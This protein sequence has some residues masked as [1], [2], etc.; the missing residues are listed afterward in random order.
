MHDSTAIILGTLPGQCRAGGLPLGI[1][2]FPR[3]ERGAGRNGHKVSLRFPLTF[4]TK[5][6]Q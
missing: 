1:K 4:G 2:A 6:A 5:L 3:D